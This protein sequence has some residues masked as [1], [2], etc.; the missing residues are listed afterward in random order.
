MLSPQ[1]AR[2]SYNPVR[3]IGH[4]G[5]NSRTWI[6]H[7]PQLGGEIVLKKI[8]KN[9]LASTT[10][11]F[12]ESK[13]L[14]A[15]TH[16]NVVQILY[17]AEDA[18]HVLIGMPLY[19]QGSLKPE[20]TGRHVPIR[21]VVIWACQILS[22]LHNVHS[23]GLIHFDIKPDNIL[24]SDRREALVSDFGLARQM[25]NGVAAP[26]KF[27]RAATPPEILRGQ[28]Q[29]DL[30]FDIYQFGLTLYRLC[31][32]DDAFKRQF[33]RFL[34]GGSFDAG[35]FEKEVLAERF[36]DRN[37]L[38]LHV[39]ARLKRVVRKCLRSD[40]ADRYQSALAIANDIAAVDGPELDWQL[41][42]IGT[43]KIWSKNENGTD[44]ILEVD[45]NV[46]NCERRYASGSVRK[47][48]RMCGTVTGKQIADFLGGR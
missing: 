11:W 23:K 3:E 12:D 29:F 48:K 19:A 5:R 14:Y 7:D 27:Y 32:G 42:E 30:T 26:L 41:T 15:S 35:V 2:I 25:I 40:P 31:A 1:V 20:I 18:D 46:A 47:D 45:G 33:G 13:A 8:V 34:I 6:V 43:K 17:A 28:T 38:P 44:V 21:Q 24:L 36:P 37:L 16:P 4:H 22:G 10:G 9:S 39:P